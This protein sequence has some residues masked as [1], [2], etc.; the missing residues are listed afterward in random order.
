MSSGQTLWC[1]GYR[2][3]LD[4]SSWKGCA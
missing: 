4:H 2:R 1:A 3:P